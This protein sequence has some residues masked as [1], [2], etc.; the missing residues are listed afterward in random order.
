M[1]AVRQIIYV[2]FLIILLYIIFWCQQGALVKRQTIPLQGSKKEKFRKDIEL[3]EPQIIFVGNSVLRAGVDPNQFSQLTGKRTINLMLD[4][5]ASAWWYLTLKNVVLRT[6][7]KPEMVGI[8]FR[9]HYLTDPSFRVDGMYKQYIEE[10]ADT[11]E[12]LLYRLAYQGR[13][14]AFTYL[15]LRY[16]PLFQ[17]KDQVRVWLDTVIKDKFVSTVIKLEPGFPDKAIERVFA[18]ENMDKNL[19]T[20]RQLAIES[21]QDNSFY[22]FPNEVEQS[23][24][25]HMI[26]LAKDNDIKL[27]FVRL[28]RRRDTEP[29]KEPRELK[30]Y[31]LDLRAY[32]S[33]NNIPFLDFTYDERI[34]IE[35]FDIGDH[36]TYSNGG[37]GRK[38]FTQILG[39]D[40]WPIIQKL[41]DNTTRREQ[42]GTVTNGRIMR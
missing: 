40:M 29:D 14:D 13:M 4:G 9:D 23:F 7:H 20:V 30:K 16:C 41:Q 6:S 39:D 22:N 25:P 10:M 19:L 24:L 3:A 38:I 5:S 15:L 1:F 27:F 28:K 8:F 33:E 17:K 36:L 34:Q 37:I 12:P 31:I 32:F 26:K 21:L 18:D 35:H 11:E 2:L 42:S